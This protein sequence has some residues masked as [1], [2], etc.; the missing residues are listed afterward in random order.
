M[1]S[2]NHGHVASRDS[3]FTFRMTSAFARF[4]V[5]LLLAI[6]FTALHAAPRVD[7]VSVDLNPLIDRAAKSPT[8]F[9]VDIPHAASLS[10]AGDWS[11][12]GELSIWTYSTRIPGAVSMS[13]HASRASFPEGALLSVTANGVR[14]VY[15]ADDIRTGEIWSRIGRGDSLAF[16][17]RV[18]AKDASLVRLDIASLQAGYRGFGVGIRNHRRYDEIRK[19]SLAMTQELASCSENW[20]CHIT[21]TSTGPGEATAALVIAGVG[22]CTGVLLNNARGD[23]TPYML[24]ARHC[25]NGDSDGGAPY[26]AG[27][28]RVYWNAVS[29][30]GDTMGSIYDPGIPS[31]YGAQTVVEQQDAWL[32]RLNQ[33]PVVDSYYAGWD[34]TGA[35]F[36]G[37]FTPH[38]SL[39]GSRQFVG[40]H[41]QAAYFTLPIGSF[42]SVHY[43]STVWGTVNEIGN[44]GGGASGGGLFNDVGRL[45]GTVVRGNDDANQ[46]GVCPVASPPAP[47]QMDATTLSTAFSGV[48]NSTDDPVSTTGAV[49]LQS[50][51]DPDHTGVQVLDGKKR[52]IT[53]TMVPSNPLTIDT[54]TLIELQWTSSPGAQACTASGGVSGDGWTG[55]LP[56]SGSRKVTRYDAGDTTYTVTCTDGQSRSGAASATVRWNLGGVYLSLYATGLGEYGVPFD[57]QWD[58]TVTPCTAGGGIPGWGGAVAPKG[59]V[60]L[61]PTT[62]GTVVFTLTCGSGT[63]VASSNYPISFLEPSV[64]MSADAV[65]ARVD[66]P[67]NLSI[68]RY[69]GPCV[70]TGGASGDGWAGS[71][72]VAGVSTYVTLQINESVPGTYTY[73][74][75][76]GSGGHVASAQ[77]T[78]TF[79]SDPPAV[80]IQA[81]RPTPTV[82]T[83]S[84]TISW[85]S[86]VRPCDVT[87]DAPDR[88][89]YFVALQGPPHGSTNLTAYV[90][91]QYVYR[92]KCGS[93][94]N[95]VQNTTTV[96]WTGTPTAS[97]DGLTEAI[98]NYPFT[99]SYFANILPC[100]TSG[101]SP[102]DG[103]NGRTFARDTYNYLSVMEQNVGAQTFTITC[104]AGAQ[105]I[106]ASKTINVVADAPQVALTPDTE[107]QLTG[108]PITLTWS[109][110]VAPCQRVSNGG[111]DGW[112][113]TSVGASGSMT[114]TQNVPG[115]YFYRITCGSVLNATAEADLTFSNYPPPTLTSSKAQSPTGENVTLAWASPDGSTCTAAGGYPDDG[116]SG[117]RSPSGS[118]DVRERT[119]NTG[120][121]FFY[122]SCGS[123]PVVR[124]KV[125]FYD[126]PV[127]KMNAS[128]TTASVGDTVY[129]TWGVTNADSCTAAGGNQADGWTGT[130]S[131]SGGNMPV[132]ATVA[133]TY[134]YT[135]NCVGFADTTATA[136]VTVTMNVVPPPPP[137]NSG[138]G[139]SKWRWWRWRRNGPTR[140][141][142]VA[143]YCATRAAS[144]AT[145]RGSA[146]DLPY[147][148][149][150]RI[151]SRGHDE[152]A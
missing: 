40:W 51:L 98:R 72:S 44:G 145:V 88:D 26:I 99:V 20:S 141:W 124:A 146:L 71:L 96:N 45:V 12:S 115:P 4:T 54:G 37:G 144:A 56:V 62:V 94:A 81:S 11:T 127:V 55:S 143:G 104:G 150:D 121:V 67:V 69:G 135:I 149:D 80:S 65:T 102:A 151:P 48:F 6:C 36:T 131:A 90:I 17:L 133:G 19:Q 142:R 29:A 18:R 123:S 74:L 111:N 139:S 28:M 108:Q 85:D 13:F 105:S 97:V 68:A 24:T 147:D 61:T 57:L 125:Q 47:S 119:G 64:A 118:F 78:V 59:K 58:S 10:T 77:T 32:V 92:V 93:G 1:D 87:A 66:Q 107:V 95:A 129:L 134:T 16:E 130:L 76:C 7:V 103:W 14:Y 60:T 73:T 106:T 136:N 86:N 117:S 30:C 3:M 70:K 46:V 79:T 38:H 2:K 137:A 112:N 140:S 89:G 50:V 114:V 31:Q 100:T 82:G 9:A 75:T 113:G 122:I 53:V 35:T 83:D 116:W 27:A 5:G 91:G 84:I 138:G 120:Y 41:G 34:A 109:S 43:A 63:R 126:L 25:E 8:R 21:A 152:A 23:G 128:A 22:Q 49:T 39:G 132:H 52:D 101:G 110:N 33:P 42:E 15:T 148:S